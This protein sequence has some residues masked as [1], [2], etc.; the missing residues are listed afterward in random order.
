[1]SCPPAVP[2]A[3]ARRAFVLRPTSNKKLDLFAADSRRLAQE[4]RPEPSRLERRG[5]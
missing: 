4:P 3:I 5:T 1:V 2:K